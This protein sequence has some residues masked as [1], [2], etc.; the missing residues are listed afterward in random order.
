[1][2]SV[3]LYSL[4]SVLVT[5]TAGFVAPASWLGLPVGAR[6]MTETGMAVQTVDRSNKSDRLDL[7]LTVIDKKPANT[8][9]TTVGKERAPVKILDGC[10]PVFSPLSSSA[11]ANLPGRCLA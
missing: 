7:P 10:D 6:P 9:A 1:M 2:R 11:Q 8:P 5:L 3:V 4:A